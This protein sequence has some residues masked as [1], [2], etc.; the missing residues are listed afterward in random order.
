[1]PN[2][3]SAPNELHIELL[4]SASMNP[5]A[6][7]DS[8]SRVQM[9]GGH[10]SQALVIDGATPR[11]AITGAERE[12]GRFTF[13]LKFPGDAEII[14]V[15]QK[16]PQTLGRDSIQENPLTLVIYEMVDTKEVCV[17]Q[18]PR[19]HS[20]HP[21]F[22]FKYKFKSAMNKLTPGATIP[23][24]TVLADSPAVDDDGNYMM[25]T[26]TKVAFMS[27]PGII[28]D[29]VIVSEEYLK[30]L[31]SKGFEKRLASWGKNWYPLNL[32]GNDE[33]YKPFPDVGER[34]R[35]DGLLFA[36]RRLDDDE[37]V[38]LAPVEM[39]AAA[40]REPDHIFDRLVYAPRGAIV[41]DIDVRHDSRAGVPPTPVGMEVQTR[42]YYEAT[43]R[44]HE[45]ILKVYNELKHRRKDALH[46]SPEFHML[47]FE[48]LAYIGDAT[49]HRYI[50]M[51]QRV[52]L[53]DW[54]VEATLE[55]DVIPNVP[56]KLT[57]FHGGK[58]VICS[59]W[60][61]EDMPVDQNG[62]RAECIM[63][64]DSTIK[65][66]NIGRLYEQYI[67]A[68][69]EMVT[70][71]VREWMV[72]PTDE[73]I[74][75]AWTYVLRYY[76]I[77]SPIQFQLITGPNYVQTPRA[78]L[79]YLVKKG[80]YLYIPPNNPVDNPTMI[81]TLRSEY[82]IHIGPV[83]Y[84]GRSG[85]VVTTTE[86]I[87]IGSLYVMLLEKTGEDFS[88]TSVARLQHFGIPARMTKGDKYSMPG[89]GNPVRI[90]GEAENRSLAACIGGDYTAELME[91]SN[92]PGTTKAIL[93]N[94][95][96]SEKPTAIKEIVDRK[97]VSALNSRSKAFVDHTLQCAG[98]EF[99]QNSS[100][101]HSPVI[102]TERVVLDS[103]RGSK[104][105]DSRR[106]A[107]D[108]PPDAA[109]GK[110]KKGEEED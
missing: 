101:E 44:Y 6:G 76:E 68:T 81:Q 25:G 43:Y 1:M 84:R 33:V 57:D 39:T 77:V 51:F 93:T 24:A 30:K 66:M 46:I 72:N 86:N 80:I 13:N 53:D 52:P 106:I 23:G 8:G 59:V 90:T 5:Y 3:L 91:M 95:V 89:R 56:F 55:Y 58:G 45:Q 21:H 54:R 50:Q 67:N 36:M 73:N 100:V 61:T 28:E 74:A 70:N 107:Y 110:K 37:D 16:Y 102:Y 34:V 11:R 64:G 104:P 60:K 63:D 17:M 38:Y 96:R 62:V 10:L 69:S 2:S 7:N 22:G 40:L 20:T 15:I 75:A 99:V 14:A 29:G 19:F 18:I 9:L 79:E 12:F 41:R 88:G 87:L 71:R 82:P 65:R 32:Y 109:K 108:D 26:E 35:D 97:K 98:I 42:K 31:V 103:R 49:K 47:V 83:T 92:S 4:A 85:N 94:L 105:E 48:A 78:H 27:V